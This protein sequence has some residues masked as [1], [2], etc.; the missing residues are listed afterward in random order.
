MMDVQDNHIFMV[1]V[2]SNFNLPIFDINYSKEKKMI[3]NIGTIK[4]SAFRHFGEDE[5]GDFEEDPLKNLE[6][7]AMGMKDDGFQYLNQ[8]ANMH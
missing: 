6:V 4:E 7:I 1:Q 2:N 5:G 3:A 8:Q